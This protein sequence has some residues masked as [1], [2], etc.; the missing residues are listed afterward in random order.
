VNGFFHQ[1]HPNDL[2]WKSRYYETYPFL[3]DEL[4]RADAVRGL[5]KKWIPTGSTFILVDETRLGDETI[6][7][8]RALPFLESQGEYAGPPAD[9]ETAIRELE[10]MRAEGAS[11]VAF[12]W[13]AFWW[14]EHYAG[15]HEHLRA[16]FPCALRNDNLVVFDLRREP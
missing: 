8:S 7:G 1:W 11:F 10:R 14:L 16:R 4:H 15:L 5:L 6:A 12:A 2:A 3:L 13:M 9:D